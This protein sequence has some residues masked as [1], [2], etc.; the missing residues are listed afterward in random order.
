LL[1]GD[2]ADLIGSGEGANPVAGDSVDGGAGDDDIY[3]GAEDTVS[4]GTGDDEFHVD[5]GSI[6]GG[7]VSIDGG[8][9]GTDGFADGSENGND[10]DILNLAQSA[11]GVDVVFSA[12]GESGTVNG[13]DGDAE[14]DVNFAEIE[15][16]IATNA[17]DTIDGSAA[18][19]GINVDAAIGD[20]SITGG[21]GDDI[22][23]AGAGA[24]TIQGGAGND[25]IDLGGNDG[26]RDVV[27]VENGDGQ[28]T[29]TGIEGPI[30]NGDGTYTAQDQLDVTG[31]THPTTG[32]P[33][34]TADVTL[35]PDGA[36]NLN[37]VF[38]DG[39]TL[40]LEN[41][42]APSTDPTDPATQNWLGALGIPI[43]G[44]LNY[45]VE[46]TS[47]GDLIDASY[48]GDPEG[49][50]VDAGDNQTGTDHDVIAAG[51]GDDTVLAGVGDDTIVM[52][53]NFG[54]DTIQGGETGETN[55]DVLDA[56]ALTTNV[57]LDLSVGEA[58]D[59][60]TR[61]VGTDNT[62]GEFRVFRIDPSFNIT[63]V[64]TGIIFDDG[65]E[66]I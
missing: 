37:L 32:D 27:V 55:G 54:D 39:T 57:V 63:A 53:D 46:G 3:F 20:D 58:A 24:D 21:S 33:V 62:F 50:L 35:T 66:T 41:T 47:S 60:D 51:A 26:L 49:D 44:A 6:F 15:K 38:P 8:S 52:D 31:L 30:D 34:T 1:G 65:L 36:G 13:L 45:I 9:D 29:I 42:S 48:T 28:D 59:L 7:A 18:T 5:P 14:V 64:E 19:T 56:S 11:N 12:D 4:G 2:G 23:S 43:D 17:S 10:G 25:S 40:L 61:D 22:V 16:V